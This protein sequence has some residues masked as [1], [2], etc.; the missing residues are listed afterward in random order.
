MYTKSLAFDKISLE[1][2]LGATV[3]KATIDVSDLD[4]NYYGNHV[5]TI[6]RHP[7]ETERRMMLRV[8]AFCLHAGETLEFGR[9]L[10]TEGEPA[11]WAID[12]TGNINTWVDLGCPDLKQIRRAAG[13]SDH[14]CILTYDEA[15]IATWWASHQGDFWKIPKLS[16]KKVDDVSCDRLA[17][18]AVRNMKL[19]VTIQDGVVWVSNDTDN[20][21]IDV[22]VLQEESVSK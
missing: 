11:L 16:I 3:Y 21:Q 5:L 12:D 1:M 19:S 7:S 17:S 6:A 18:M 13:R 2:A 15:K 14:V 8:L 20:I 9:G 22:E 10:S 4:R